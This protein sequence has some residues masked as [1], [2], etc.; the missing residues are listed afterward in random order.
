ME[1]S[2]FA[3]SIFVNTAG[4]QDVIYISEGDFSVSRWRPSCFVFSSVFSSLP[5]VRHPINLQL[6]HTWIL[7]LF[8]SMY[9]EGIHNSIQSRFPV[10]AAHIQ[11]Y[12]SDIS[13]GKSRY[14]MHN[15]SFPPEQLV[16]LFFFFFFPFSFPKGLQQNLE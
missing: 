3:D 10:P 11:R 9:D 5:F 8:S 12:F 13:S 6:Q 1:Q 14:Q 15:Y 2:L 7:F 4:I 16:E